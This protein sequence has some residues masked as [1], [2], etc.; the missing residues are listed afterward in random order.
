MDFAIIRGFPQWKSSS[1]KKNIKA[2]VN[3]QSFSLN[4]YERRNVN[5]VNKE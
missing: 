1:R 5:V 3:I 2:N 4:G